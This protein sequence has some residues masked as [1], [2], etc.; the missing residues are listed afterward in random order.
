MAKCN[1]ILGQIQK[2]FKS[3]RNSV[4]VLYNLIWNYSFFCVLFSYLPFSFYFH[5]ETKCYRILKYIK[6]SWIQLWIPSISVCPFCFICPFHFLFLFLS[7]PSWCSNNLSENL[8]ITFCWKGGPGR[9]IDSFD[10]SDIMCRFHRTIGLIL[11]TVIL[12]WSWDCN[13]VPC[14]GKSL[15]MCLGSSPTWLQTQRQ[16]APP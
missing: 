11:V 12:V 13:K 4:Y 8:A 5:F 6:I 9:G 16:R 3:I 1:W 10:H 7:W 14:L 15:G 2:C